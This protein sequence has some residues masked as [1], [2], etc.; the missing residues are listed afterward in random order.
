MAQSNIGFDPGIGAEIAIPYVDIAD[1]A[2]RCANRP[3]S[4]IVIGVKVPFEGRVIAK[5]NRR[6]PGADS[7]AAIAKRII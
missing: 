4:E 3:Q 1:D 2:D 7:E 6:H 5:I